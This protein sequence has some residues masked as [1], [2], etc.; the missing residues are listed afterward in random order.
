MRRM[1]AA[2]FAA[3]LARAEKLGNELGDSAFE[4]G[5][6]L[7]DT[8]RRALALSARFGKERY[9]ILFSGR[10]WTIV[11][12]GLDGETKFRTKDAALERWE[13]MLAKWRQMELHERVRE[14]MEM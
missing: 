3:L 10:R 1:N 4:A 13:V 2:Q 12:P 14:S 9:P 5:E 6:R 11:H 8:D 7:T